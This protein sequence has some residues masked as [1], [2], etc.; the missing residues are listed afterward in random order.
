MIKRKNIKDRG[1]IRFSEYFREFENGNKVAVVREQSF[2]PA[3]PKTIQGKTGIVVGQRG[4][5]YIIQ[6]KDG[7]ITK[8][9]I[10]KAVHLKP[11]I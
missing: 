1:K 6:M 3:F 11:I 2:Q 5:S 4:K 10:I 7:K 9:Y 8:T